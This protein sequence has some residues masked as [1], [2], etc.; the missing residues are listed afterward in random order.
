MSKKNKMTIL[1]TGATGL[2]G[3]KLVLRLFKQGNITIRLLTRSKERAKDTFGF[4]VESFE[5]DPIKGYIEKNALA[6][7]DGI[8][9]L[10]GE[11]VAKGRWTKKKKQKIIDSR[12]LIF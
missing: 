10:A 12:I 1:V 11:S 3:K 4:P 2:V 7:V 8:I 9:H 5:W 6:G